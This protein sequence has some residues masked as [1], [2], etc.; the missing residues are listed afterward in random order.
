MSDRENRGRVLFVLM[1]NR[2]DKLDID[3]KRAGRLDR[4]IPF[5]YA[6][7]PEGVEVVLLAQL[8]RHKIEHSIS[9][10][11]HRELISEPLLGYS[12]AELEAIVLLANNYIEDDAQ[13]LDAELLKQAIVDFLPSRDELMLEYMELLAVFET[14]SRS[15]LPPKFREIPVEDLQERMTELRRLID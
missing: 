9:F 6:S 15:L 14:S 5:F 7:A 13:V 3:I 12:N 4:K 2:P 8:A 11:E 1:T 10:P